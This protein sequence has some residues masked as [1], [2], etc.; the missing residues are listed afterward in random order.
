MTDAEPSAATHEALMAALPT[1]VDTLRRRRASEIPAGFIDAYV[2][3]QWLEWHGGGLRVTET[4]LNVC[5][6]LKQR[7]AG[8]S[9]E[10]LSSVDDSDSDRRTDKGP[11]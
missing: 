5:R 8:E 3:L 4:G 9:A 7:M 1:T 11:R 10:T 2:A 6:Q